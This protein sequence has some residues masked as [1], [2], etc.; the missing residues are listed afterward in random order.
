MMLKRRSTLI[1][2]MLCIALLLT[3]CETGSSKTRKVIPE[4]SRGL[5]LGVAA[6]NQPID[7]VSSQG[8]VHILW[9]SVGNKSLSYVRLDER[10]QVEFRSELAI[11][12]AHP[13][14]TRLLLYRDGTY[15]ALWTDNPNIPRAVFLAHFDSDGSLLSGPTRLTPE[16]VRVADV[17]VAR[18]PDGNYD[19][20]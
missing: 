4:W 8:K 15:G 2:A 10:G 5:Q 1:L 18:D 3:A 19:L 7:I 13:N 17:A 6:L 20:F 9:V 12:G 16:G 11:G 14:D